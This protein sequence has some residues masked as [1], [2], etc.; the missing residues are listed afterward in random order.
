MCCAGVNKSSHSLRNEGAKAGQINFPR[1]GIEPNSVALTRVSTG[2]RLSS[3][4]RELMKPSL[5]R[6]VGS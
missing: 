1:V 4:P 2:V 3:Q 5:T 6:A